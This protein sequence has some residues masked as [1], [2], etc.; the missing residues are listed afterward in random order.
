MISLQSFVAAFALVSA[1]VL[2][3]R[4]SGSEAA[5][6]EAVTFNKH[7][8][9][10]FFRTCVECHRPG[11]VAPF[12]LL[13]YADAR[14]RAKTIQE[15]TS[16]R[17]MPPWKSV[18]GHGSFIGER[19]LSAKET[20]LI[21]RWVAQDKPEGDAKDLPATPAF[22][23]GWKLGPPDIVVQMPEP[24]EVPAEGRD[25]YRNF[26]FSLEVPKGK[27]IKAAEF[28][29]SNRKVVHHA[30]LCVDVTGRARKK[31]EAD[32]AQG[33]AG[34]TTPPGQLFPGSMA[35]WT[36]GRD[37]LPL[38][39]GISMPW[40][41]GADFVMQLHL[42]PSGKPETEQSSVGIY[43]TDQPPQRSMVDL[44]LLDMKIDI[45]AGE[46]SYRTRAELTLPIDVET[47]GLFPHMHM[48]GRDF[49]VTAHPP[50]G[51]P[52]PL[53]WINDWD[54]N[55]QVY[56]QYNA[57]MKLTAGTRIVMEGVHDNSSD[58]A[59][60]PSKPPKRV[61]WGE[62]TTDEMSVVFLQVMPVR[63]EEFDKLG[64]NGRGNKLGLIRAEGRK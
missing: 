51:E 14:K 40:K 39:E 32:P 4:A 27:Y 47:V 62:Q 24:Y 44:L 33:Y 12:S 50:Q 6:A 9:P 20:D 60:N 18:E 35:T 57:P 2:Q 34:S 37:P 8:A 42:H 7:I 15:V 29:P 48:I 26:V 49:K 3:P 13:T 56:Y 43:L 11:E 52:F 30:E 21:D 25:V 5:V 28:R 36:P 17:V 38:P 53:L 31:D 64:V 41:E 46:R 55:W 22:K 23:E 63:E 58:N 59:H 10:I 16:G 19:R 45:P 1:G 54:F 61:T